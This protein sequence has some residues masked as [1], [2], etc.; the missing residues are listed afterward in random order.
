MGEERWTG[1]VVEVEGLE[2]VYGQETP[3]PIRALRGVSFE[4]P[5]GDFV[6]V[7]GHSGSGKTTLMNIL[8]CMDRP[9][10]GIYR[11][12][13]EDVSRKSRRE[14]AVIRNRTL[15]FIFQSFHLL[16]RI[17]ALANC[18]L[19][20]Q[21]SKGTSASERRERAERVL[22]RVGLKE[23]MSRK[24]AELS[25]GQQQRVAIARALVNHPSLL[26]ADEPTG[27]LDSRT[28]LE[29][30][31]LLQELHAEGLTILTVTHDAGVA[32]CGLRT[33]RLRDGKIEEIV[34][35]PQPKDA[36]SEWEK[37]L[38]IPGPEKK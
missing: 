17:S 2:K 24:P 35:N 9:T 7:M 6:A 12:N 33:I 10:A 21:Y 22:I 28:G 38:R 15:G 19:P 36:R 11:L 26:L 3:N 1:P 29:I 27:N 16:P 14:L 23:E 13:G 18:E 37:L 32:A 5:E 31:A 30:L 25:G 8:G 34:A 4:V 20:M